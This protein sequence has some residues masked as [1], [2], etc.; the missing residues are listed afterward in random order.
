MRW[1]R[2][3][4]SWRKRARCASR[5]RGRPRKQRWSGCCEAGATGRHHALVLHWVGADTANRGLDTA[6]PGEPDEVPRRVRPGSETG[7]LGAP[8]TAHRLHGWN[9][10][11]PN[12]S[13]GSRL[14]PSSPALPAVPRAAPPPKGVHFSYWPTGVEQDAATMAAVLERAT[15]PSWRCPMRA[16]LARAGTVGRARSSIPPSALAVGAC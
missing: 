3:V 14:R 4:C 10:G 5:S 2:T 6:A 15:C 13:D 7:A 8:W 16:P 1:C 12:G 9:T 11:P